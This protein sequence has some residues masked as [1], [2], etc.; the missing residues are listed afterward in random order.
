VGHTALTGRKLW[1]E[2]RPRG[3]ETQ[4]TYD[5]QGRVWKI[6]D[7]NGHTT[8]YEYDTQSRL[9]KIHYAGGKTVTL[10]YDADGNLSG[11]NDGVTS[12]TYT[13]NAS[14]QKLSEP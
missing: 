3:Q 2:R 5:V 10:S 4:Y 14:G 8:E 11:Y 9:W 1:K 13:Y 6:L 7:A 12:A